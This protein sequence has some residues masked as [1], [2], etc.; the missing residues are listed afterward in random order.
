MADRKFWQSLI[1]FGGRR[2]SATAGKY[3][4]NPACSVYLRETGAWVFPMNVRGG[5]GGGV[6][7]MVGPAETI[8]NEFTERALGEA[9]LAAISRSRFEQWDYKSPV[10]E[11][12]AHQSAGFKSYGDL[13]RGARLLKVYRTGDQFTISAWGASKG[14]R[15]EPIPGGELTCQNDPLLIGN[16]IKDLS[17]R[18]VARVA[19]AKGKSAENA[20]PPPE[21]NSGSEDVPVPFGYK[22][23]WIAVRSSNGSHVAQSIGLKDV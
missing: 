6:G 18:C 3:T 21:P 19:K 1:S 7:V 10:P 20:N 11:S 17:T 5:S 16:A 14:G 8:Q 12:K 2:K 23:C 13:E 15:Y 9:V 4:F 22:I